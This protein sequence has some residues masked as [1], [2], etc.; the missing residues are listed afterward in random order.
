MIRY[1]LHKLRLLVV[2]L[3]AIGCSTYKQNGKCYDY[4]P[5][6]CLFMGARL[7]CEVNSEGCETCNCIPL[8]HGKDKT[9]EKREAW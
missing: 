7:V 5:T 8:Q 6:G 4:K 1:H 9:L 2:L 3:P